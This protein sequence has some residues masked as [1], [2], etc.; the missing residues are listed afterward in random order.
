MT[1]NAITGA[2]GM[3]GRHLVDALRPSGGRIRALLMPKEPVPASFDDVEVIRGD[4]RDRELM[5]SFTAGADTVFH[6]AALVGRDAN[7]ASLEAARDVNVRGTVHLLEAARRSGAGRF[8]FLSTCCVYGLYGLAEQ[9]V[10][11]TSPHAPL[12]LPYDIT[13]TEAD[14][15]VSRQDPAGLPWSIL[16]I[17]VA[18]GGNHTLDKPTAMSL[19]RLGRAGLA[20]RPLGRESWAN[21]AFGSDVA[22]ALLRLADHP[23]AVGQTFIYSESV[24]LHVLLSWIAGELGVRLWPIPVPAS[25]LSAVARARKS[26][27]L[28]ANRRR[29]A[30]E[31]I[32]RLLDFSPPVGLEHG[33]RQTLRH[34]RSAGLLP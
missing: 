7:R 30:N 24:P 19:I 17:P 14:E 11:E 4:V 31:K 12:G 32:A 6:L 9:V 25:V 28:L 5:L 16:Q 34:Y 20:P 22:A 23:A 3:I 10:D 33:V 8:V 2:G 1:L 26:A 21:Y 15:L 29:F 18:L 27:A 13:K